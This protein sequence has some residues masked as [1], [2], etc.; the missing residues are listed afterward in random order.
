[1]SLPVLLFYAVIIQRNNISIL[2][3]N[4]FLLQTLPLQSTLGSTITRSSK[5]LVVSLASALFV[6]IWRSHQTV[7]NLALVVSI[8]VI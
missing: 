5:L 3:H 4:I 8:N 6:T 7:T 1:M 2:G